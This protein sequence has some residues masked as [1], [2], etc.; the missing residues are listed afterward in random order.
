MCLLPR[1]QGGVGCRHDATWRAH[2]CAALARC[3]R[4]SWSIQTATW[5]LHRPGCR[6]MPG[7]ERGQRAEGGCSRNC[8]RA[9]G[10]APTL[11]VPKLALQPCNL[12]CLH[13]CRQ[14][15]Q[16]CTRARRL[17][18]VRLQHTRRRQRHRGRW[19]RQLL[20]RS[21]SG[22]RCCTT[23]FIAARRTVLDSCLLLKN[24]HWLAAS[25]NSSDCVSSHLCAKR[26]NIPLSHCR[27]GEKRWKE[28]GRAIE[29][30]HV[31]MFQ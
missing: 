5:R 8:C 28:A 29:E 13:F 26:K 16:Y 6:G 19:R 18:G 9:A 15:T 27:N 31:L 3:C 14:R 1:G 24:R 25:N 4:L 12:L 21:M 20:I 7:L 22:C 2:R 10:V 17:G 23:L 11:A 30:K